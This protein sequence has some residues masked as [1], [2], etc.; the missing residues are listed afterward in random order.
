MDIE[1]KNKVD[2]ILEEM[3]MVYRNDSRPWV[4]GYSGG[5]DSTTVVQLA[6]MML[7]RLSPC[8]RNKDIYVVSSDTLIENPIV[9]GFL[10]QNSAL[11]NNGA[12][13]KNLPLY[14]YLIHPD[15]NNTYWTNV[16]G[17]GLPTP[18]SIRFRWCTE[19][20]KIKPSNK[21]IEEKVKENGEVV[22][23]LGVRKSESIARGIRI[24]NREIDGYLLTPHETLNNTYVYNPIVDLST[25]DVWDILLDNNGITPW[26]TS[27]N[28][29]HSLYLGADGGE[30]PFT[31]T[32]DKE[33][34]SCG[35]SRFGCWI[36]TVVNEDK[37]LT[38][39]I[40][41]GETYL[42]P[43]LDFRTWIL[44]IRNKHEF[45]MQYRRD[46][47]HYYKKIYLNKLPLL[48]NLTIDPNHIFQNESGEYYIDIKNSITQ[49]Q[50]GHTVISSDKDKIY[51]ELL[52]LTRDLQIIPSKIQ[53][54]D[55]G[56]FINV[57][58]YGP[59]TFEA[60]QLI[61]KKLLETQKIMNEEI[62]IELITKE[63][64]ET[65][66]KIWDQEEDL[67]CRTLVDLYNNIIGEKLPWDEY[68]KSIFD[69]ETLKEIKNLC[70]ED[71][72]N[73]NLITKLLIETHNFKYF[74]NKKYLDVAIDKILNQKHL[75][76]ELMEEI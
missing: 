63:E 19:R 31:V 14:T 38:G 52:P 73:E 69:N 58:G 62:E 13:A 8:D 33:T 41:N 45:R 2:Y 76:K 7:E 60:R 70:I 43:L 10:K 24:K 56:E 5:K 3:E 51:L 42:Q 39:F 46:G 20:L 22:V 16:I 71:N 21:F 18:T 49:I 29:L 40:E 72:I 17:K 34:P 75:H 12:K 68:K 65:I 47:N 15:Y 50:N 27:N 61:L 25:N 57:L 26:G 35:N 36:C 53:S 59:F 55:T 54:D 23:L 1:L 48:N 9:L 74:N 6:F 44:S 37:S 28:D 64:L 67:T 66:D 32:N 30:C 11:I 4:I